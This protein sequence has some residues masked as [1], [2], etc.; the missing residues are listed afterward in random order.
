M[1]GSFV[2]VKD[3]ERHKPDHLM[4]YFVDDEHTEQQMIQA[5]EAV[6]Y[7]HCCTFVGTENWPPTEHFKDSTLDAEIIEQ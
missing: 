1:S 4:T 5:W 7:K 2:T 6:G 3:G